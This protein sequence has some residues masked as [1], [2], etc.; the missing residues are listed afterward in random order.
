[1]LD[2]GGGGSSGTSWWSKEMA[3]MW[4]Y[5]AD[6]D[7]EPMWKQSAGWQKAI[8]LAST[9]LYRLKDF[10]EKLTAAWPPE[11]SE[12]SKEYV[13]KLDELITSVQDVYD[14]AVTNKTSASNLASAIGEAK[15]KVE[16][17]YQAWLKTLSEDQNDP[18]VKK[19][20]EDL[21]NQARGHMSDLSTDLVLSQGNMVEPKPYTPPQLAKRD[22]GD[23]TG[24]SN[25]TGSTGSGS[26]GYS[27]STPAPVIPLPAPIP[28]PS[29]PGPSLSGSTQT[30]PPPTAPTPM[31]TAPSLPG[32]PGPIGAGPPVAPI[33]PQGIIK[34]TAPGP[35]NQG[36]PV[37]P[38]GPNVI[39][40]QPPGRTGPMTGPMAG[41]G[42]NPPGGVIGQQPAGGRGAGGL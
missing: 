5:I 29:G 8:D 12:A 3:T 21:T 6:V 36:R 31:P 19:R 30:L 2:S 1:M 38:L 4:Y 23:E 37:G 18:E 10:R 22:G 42:V 28:A 25:G 41:R 35:L 17:L 32:N 39:G 11:K 7:T 9:N 26:S 34:P 24:G 15:Y 14:A 40:G 13:T 27:G 20:Q 33:G 16:P